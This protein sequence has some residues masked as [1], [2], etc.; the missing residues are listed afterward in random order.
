VKD[1]VLATSTAGR[2]VV[3][4]LLATLALTVAGIG[5][6][7]AAPDRPACSAVSAPVAGP[8]DA[9]CDRRWPPDRDGQ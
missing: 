5:Q 2:P 7:T 4:L 8:G 3:A 6:A 9:G 1:P